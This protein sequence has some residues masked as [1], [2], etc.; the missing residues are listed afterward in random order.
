MRNL[1]AAILIGALAF[2]IGVYAQAPQQQPDP[3]QTIIVTGCVGKETDVLKGTE[4]VGMAD[5]FVLTR[6]AVKIGAPGAEPPSQTPPT[7]PEPTATAGMP[8]SG[9]IYRV[10]GDKEAELKAHVRHR[11]E[12]TG[13][14]KHEADARRELGAIGT[15]GK[16]PASA[17][18]PTEKNT[19]EI[20]IISF[21]ML[22]PTCGG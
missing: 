3:N 1:S 21:R 20:T 22:S 18:E 2:A 8:E 12:I 15:S 6:S 10:T 17:P 7:P 4:K 9:K 13:K 14:F 11:V 5:E 16:P 19:P